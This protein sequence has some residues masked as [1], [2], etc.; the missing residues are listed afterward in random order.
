M[1]TDRLHFL[2]LQNRYGRWRQP[3]N[4]KM[5]AP[6]KKS[7]DKSRE[8]IKK[9]RYPFADKGPYNQS[10]GFSSSHVWMWELDP[11]EGWVLKN[12]CFQTVVLE[13]TLESPLDCKEIQPVNTKGNQSRIFIGRTDAEAEALI[14]WSPDG[15]SW[16]IG[17]DLAAEKDWGQ[18]EKGMTEDRWLEG[19]M[20][21]MDMSLSK[22]KEI[23]KDILTSEDSEGKPGVPQFLGL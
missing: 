19:I 23:V 5:L 13:K 6:W 16:L 15:K 22:L 4:Y 20:E 9:Q 2:G 12:W 21:S 1:E 8:H 18:E 11:K 3:W 7:Y 10:C 14:F 17:K